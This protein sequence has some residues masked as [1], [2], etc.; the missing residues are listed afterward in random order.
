MLLEGSKRGS[1]AAQQGVGMRARDHLLHIR[2]K[3]LA[4]LSLK[5]S[6]PNAEMAYFMLEEFNGYCMENGSK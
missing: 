3:Q 4:L 6:Y 5:G 1:T 2:K